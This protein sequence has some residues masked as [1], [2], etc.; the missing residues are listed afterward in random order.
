MSSK[1][2]PNEPTEDRT[3]GGREYEV[4]DTPPANPEPTGFRR[5]TFLKAALAT[6]TVAGAASKASAKTALPKGDASV[7]PPAK[8]VPNDILAQC[9]YCGVGC[10]T[11]IQTEKGRIVGMKPDPKHPTHLLTVHGVGYALGEPDDE[12][13]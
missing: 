7:A 10:G 13:S 4:R 2:T 9:P 3:Y 6:A 1:K 12:D 5:R 11:M 8:D